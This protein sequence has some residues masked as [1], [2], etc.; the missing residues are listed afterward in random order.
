MFLC[1]QGLTWH[2]AMNL[3]CFVVVV[4][5]PRNVFSA[6]ILCHVIFHIPF[7]SDARDE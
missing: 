2:E 1:I 5:K 7:E 4:S 3:L 6:A